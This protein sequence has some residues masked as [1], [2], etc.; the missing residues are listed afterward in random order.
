MTVNLN[1]DINFSAENFVPVGTIQ[2]S[3]TASPTYFKGTFNGNNLSLKNIKILTTTQAYG[4]LGVFGYVQNATI[5]DLTVTINEICLSTAGKS[6]GG[7]IG[8]CSGSTTIEN[9]VMLPAST[10]SKIYTS[11][12][13][14]DVSINVGGLIGY[15]SCTSLYLD[16][17]AN[18]VSVSNTVN[19]T[20]TLGGIVGKF[21]GSSGSNKA[22]FCYNSGS[23]SCGTSST[24]NTYVGGILGYSETSYITIDNSL[25]GG[26]IYA[27]AKNNLTGD[28]L[29]GTWSGTGKLRDVDDMAIDYSTKNFWSNSSYN[30]YAGGIV[31]YGN[32]CK[33]SKCANRTPKTSTSVYSNTYINYIDYFYGFVGATVDSSDMNIKVPTDD[34]W[35]GDYVDMTYTQYVSNLREI[36]HNATISDCVSYDYGDIYTTSSTSTLYSRLYRV[37][38]TGASGKLLSFSRMSLSELVNGPNTSVRYMREEGEDYDGTVKIYLGK[39]KYGYAVYANAAAT[40][41]ENGYA[42]GTLYYVYDGVEKEATVW[43]NCDVYN[44]YNTTYGTYQLG[45]NYVTLSNHNSVTQ[46]YTPNNFLIDTSTGDA[47]DYIPHYENNGQKTITLGTEY[48]SYFNSRYVNS[49]NNHGSSD[50]YVDDSKSVIRN[51]KISTS[52]SNNTI[53]VKHN[54]NYDYRTMNWLVGDFGTWHTN[55]STSHEVC[56]IGDKSAVTYENKYYYMESASSGYHTP[57]YCSSTLN[58]P[59]YSYWTVTNGVLSLSWLYWED[60]TSRPY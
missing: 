58:G 20:A 37:K 32:G 56:T 27:Y 10:S 35:Y 29:S 38:I 39:D 53:Y 45:L 18:L 55:N 30:I 4:D 2:G 57:A 17:C 28:G 19:G 33:V 15:S 13:A 49:G 14:A 60:N 7:L 42:Y 11:N 3:A 40:K 50:R 48:S 31:G 51:C 21:V 25:N 16:E 8:S 24:S 34:A 46:I 47:V 9:V 22:R 44:L 54:F 52:S 1:T 59:D 43:Y 5:K 36:A 6:V 12:S 41:Y 23:L 26:S